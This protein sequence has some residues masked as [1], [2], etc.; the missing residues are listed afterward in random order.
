MSHLDLNDAEQIKRLV[1]DPTVEAMCAK[2]QAELAPILRAQQDTSII[3]KDHAA[4]IGGLEG[5]QRR[6]LLGWGVASLGVSAAITASWNWIRSK[7][8]VG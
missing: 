2:I 3:L 8:H 5:N 7:V 1:V 6:A 4:R